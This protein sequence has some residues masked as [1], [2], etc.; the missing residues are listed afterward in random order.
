MLCGGL[1]S[2][3]LLRSLQLFLGSER[4]SRSHRSDH[5][6]GD[7]GTTGYETGPPVY[8]HYPRRLESLTMCRCYYKGSTFSSVILRPWVLVRP[9]SNSRPTEPSVRGIPLVFRFVSITIFC[10][11]L[12]S[13]VLQFSSFTHICCHILSFSP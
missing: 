7:Y 8:S 10:N 12:A 9:E 4:C 11:L 13:L 1:Y 2:D 5:N 3:C 6:T